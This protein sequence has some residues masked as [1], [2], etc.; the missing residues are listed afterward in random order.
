MKN[1][2]DS[3]YKY[4]FTSCVICGPRY[5]TITKLPYDR[6]HTTMNNFPL[7]RSCQLEY[8]NP[9]DRRHHAQTTCC[10]VCGPSL[11]LF[12]KNAEKIEPPNII[13]YVA[14]RIQ[15]GSI[16]AIKGI[17]GTHLACSASNDEVILRL[18]TRKGKR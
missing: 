17:G 1:P 4:P 14:E 11:A 12:N 5:T 3:R 8:D 16:V 2:Q 6:P 7:C 9:L 18:R 13:K 15:D 10:S